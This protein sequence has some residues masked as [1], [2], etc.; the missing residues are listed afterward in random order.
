MGR[1]LVAGELDPVLEASAAVARMLRHG[2]I[3]RA[4]DLF[5][6]AIERWP[7]N[8]KLLLLKGDVLAQTAGLY[9]AAMHYAELLAHPTVAQ[10]AA[11]RLFQIVRDKSLPLDEAIA[12]V[13]RVCDAREDTRLKAQILDRLLD[14]GD[15]RERELLLDVLG[16]HSSIFRYEFKAAV[17]KTEKGECDAAIEILESA[18]RNGRSS[19][20]STFLLAELYAVSSRFSEA[21]ALLDEL[22]EQHPE[23]PEIYRR[24]VHMLQRAGDFERAVDVFEI[25][26][27]RWPQ[28]WLLIYRFNRLSIKPGRQAQIFDAISRASDD[29]QDRNDRCRFHFGLACLHN[30]HVERGYEHLT[31]RFEEPTASTAGHIVKALG[32]RSPRAWTAGSR[33]L[34]DRTREVQIVRAEGARATIVVPATFQFGNLPLAMVDALFAE[35]GLNVVYLRDLGQRAFLR[36]IAAMGATDEC[37]LIGLAKLIAELGA[38]R[39][40]FMGASAGGFTALRYAALLN[41]DVAVSFAGPTALSPVYESTRASIWNQD[42]FIKTWLARETDLPHDLVPVLSKPTRTKFRQYFG[43]LATADAQQARRIERLSGV[44]LFPM[45]GIGDHFIA[46]HMIGD[47]SFDALIEELVSA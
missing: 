26:I 35:H 14:R 4:A 30:G 3:E 27:R 23:H 47:G 33:L 22:L 17:Q 16:R 2:E 34:D 6:R 29:M 9:Q 5:D 11:P 10:W 15:P 46:H 31:A 38:K 41:G 24:L 18:R 36:G 44:T 19:E 25:A 40:I 12:L 20:P 43:E 21:V 1:G 32:A 8:S 37:T 13:K 42:F 45:P 28:D 7:K 39:T